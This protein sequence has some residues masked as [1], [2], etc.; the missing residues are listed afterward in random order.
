MALHLPNGRYTLL[1]RTFASVIDRQTTTQEIASQ[2]EFLKILREKFKIKT[3]QE[4][5]FERLFL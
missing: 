4:F 1:N 5:H 2:E 3:E